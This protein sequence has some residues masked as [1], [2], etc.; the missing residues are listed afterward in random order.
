MSTK[1]KGRVIVTFDIDAILN[2]YNSGASR[3]GAYDV[4]IEHDDGA[5]GTFTFT[6]SP[7]FFDYDSVA[8][9][10][11]SA[12]MGEGTSPVYVWKSGIR[13][14]DEGSD[15]KVTVDGLNNL[16]EDSYPHPFL[17]LTG[18]EY[19]LSQIDVGSGDGYLVGWND[20]YDDNFT[21]TRSAWGVRST[22]RF[23]MNS[24]ANV[25][26]TLLDTWNVEATE[27]ANSSTV[28]VII[29]TYNDDSTALTE[30]FKGESKRLQKDCATVLGNFFY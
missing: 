21:Y 1:Y 25:T 14:Y 3:S 15:F 5:D 17:R 20:D 8:A 12:T 9:L 27:W 7:R 22:A 10:I 29:D 23:I 13:A 30:D 18:S 4:Y 16:Q 28:R 24:T 6:Q 19:W 2:T 26:A 11:G